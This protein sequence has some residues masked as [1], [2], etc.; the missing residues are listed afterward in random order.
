M[1]LERFYTRDLMSFSRF[2]DTVCNKFRILKAYSSTTKVDIDSKILFVLL[3]GLVSTYL[4]LNYS[5]YVSDHNEQIPLILHAIDSRFLEND[6]FVSQGSNIS[7]RFFY[8]QF[9]GL[10][11]THIDLPI[12]FYILVILSVSGSVIAI[13]LISNKL[14]NNNLV[15]LISVYLTLFG[16]FTGLGGSQLVLGC[17]VPS[18]LTFTIILFALNFLLVDRYYL[19][20]ALLGLSAIIH[21]LLS[22]LALSIFTIQLI[23][24][25]VRTKI[26][27]L[28]KCL[29]VY[30]LLG[31]IGLL[32]VIL[33]ASNSSSMLVAETIAFIRHP[34]HYCPF[35]FSVKSYL[36]FSVI[37]ILFILLIYLRFT[38]I[39]KKQH[40]VVISFSVTILIMCL[41]G[42]IFVEILPVPIVIKMQLFRITPILVLFAHIYISNMIITLGS[43]LINEKGSTFCRLFGSTS[44][45]HNW[46]KCLLVAILLFS[47]I[48]ILNVNISPPQSDRTELYRWITDNT[49]NDS[50][51]L[52]SPSIEDFRLGT[53]RAIVVD[54]KAFPFTDTA[55]IEWRERLADVTGISSENVSIYHGFDS[56]ESID[57]NY[58]LLT[59][60]DFTTLKKKYDF[61]YILVRA[62]LKYNFTE[63]YIDNNYRIYQI[64]NSDE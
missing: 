61:D 55:I 39:D 42:T 48:I 41:I 51:F 59:E 26:P 28:F 60:K 17:L 12:L 16:P 32:P 40:N 4:Y 22:I 35:N 47:I 43:I 25:L 6:W 36:L 3:T 44:A 14:F 9:L 21:P 1:G 63:V 52:I 33:S 29:T 8:S 54:W 62:S 31:S 37:I 11:S 30:F 24:P 19:A 7:P 49:P 13:Y 23:T 15:S 53:K 64:K 34:H 57:R 46:V 18:V 50:I 5:F 27:Q 56:L 58:S 2:S 38:P 20:F 45:H 10:L